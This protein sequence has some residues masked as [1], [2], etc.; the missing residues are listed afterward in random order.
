MGTWEYRVIEGSTGAR[1]V[2]I[3]CDRLGGEGWE[4]AGTSPVLIR[5]DR[6]GMTDKTTNTDWVMIFKRQLVK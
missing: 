2:Q 1:E 4:L 5:R 6:G 3:S